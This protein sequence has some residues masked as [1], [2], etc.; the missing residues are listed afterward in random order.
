MHK[1]LDGCKGSFTKCP[2][3]CHLWRW[4]NT[5]GHMHEIA[6]V[7]KASGIQRRKT[8]IELAHYAT[9][10]RILLRMDIE[11]VKK[12]PLLT[13]LTIMVPILTLR[14]M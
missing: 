2:F 4:F 14:S 3:I 9:G 5:T 11:G 10:H 8:I 13:K 1:N 6:H 7:I 12:V